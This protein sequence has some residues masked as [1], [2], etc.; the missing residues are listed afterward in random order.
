[1]Q[2]GAAHPSPAYQLDRGDRGTVHRKEA[3]YPDPRGDLA[4]RKGLADSAAPLGDDHALERLKP[5]LVAFTNPDHD[6]DGISRIEC[7][8]VRAQALTG[9]LCPPFHGRIPLPSG[10]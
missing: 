8:N 9:H 4:D 3:L 7:R 1:V 10:M 5:L 2:L 6:P